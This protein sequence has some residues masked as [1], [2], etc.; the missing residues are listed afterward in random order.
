MKSLFPNP[1]VLGIGIT[2]LSWLGLYGLK[3]LLT[4]RVSKFI[5]R[6]GNKW[7]DI[8]VHAMEQTTQLWMLGT[9]AYIASQ[10]ILYPREYRPKVDSAF[11]ILT[12]IQV[13]IW[14]NDLLD[15]WIIVTINRKTR[16]NPAA[17]TS[18]G[19]IQLLAKIFILSAVTLFTLNNLGIKITTILAGLGVGGIA[20]ALALQ[21]I[22]GDLFSSLSIVM[23]KPFVVGDFIVMDQFMGDVEKIGI[24]TTRLRS[25]G[26]E[27]IIISNSDILAARIR[28]FK[29]MRERRVAFIL[30]LPLTTRGEEMR[31][32]V[33]LIKA[34]VTSRE[35]LR[36]DRCHFMSINRNSMDIEL[37]YWVLSD[38]INTHMDIQE[39]VLLDIQLSFEKENLT[40]ARPVQT[41]TVE[42]R[43][44]I[45][46]TEGP[47]VET[48]EGRRTVS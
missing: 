31:R 46:R 23:D 21:K 6:P 15:R 34:I 41:V 2:L 48:E 28:N 47:R 33:S 25:L 3:R 20:V 1:Y 27:Q 8:I 29:R 37:V 13:G 7:D 19:L 30:S 22:L 12:M 32:A 40:F 10:F 38:D 5:K 45:M 26:G 16:H 42:P 44:F 43:E 24:K 11:F 9:A 36:L 4:L 39:E 17:A 35:K 18:I 14:A